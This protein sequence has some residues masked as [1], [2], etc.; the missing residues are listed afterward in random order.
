MI[1]RALF[2]V[3][4]ATA[5]LMTS[6]TADVDEPKSAA[7]EGSRVQ[8]TPSVTP[9]GFAPQEFLERTPLE[10]CGEY[11]LD[12]GEQVP[13]AATECLEGAIAAGG[14]ELVV[15]APTDEGDPVVT[16]IR[17]LPSGG[18]EIWA[19]VRQDK[20]AGEGSWQYSMCPGAVSWLGDPAECTHESFG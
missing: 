8:P 5:L 10:S 13:T 9:Q 7:A 15:T 3:F 6:C 18:L 20:F 12:V 14:A 4:V 1:R 2:P 19:D 11:T 17:A 16:W